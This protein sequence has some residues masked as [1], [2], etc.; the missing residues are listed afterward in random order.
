MGAGH[1]CAGDRSVVTVQLYLHD[2]PASHG[3]ATTFFPGKSYSVAYQPEAG[4]VLLFSQDLVHEGSLLREGLKYT[5]RTEAMYTKRQNLVQPVWQP[6]K[7]PAFA[8]HAC[9]SENK[10]AANEHGDVAPQAKTTD[11]VE[12]TLPQDFRAAVSDHVN[13]SQEVLSKDVGE[14]SKLLKD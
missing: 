6:A 10:A 11:T 1:P 4:S 7:A 5:L 13:G 2:V 3:G 9:E 8:S 12:A 14:Q